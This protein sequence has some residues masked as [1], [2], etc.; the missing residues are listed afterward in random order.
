MGGAR[1]GQPPTR[2][3]M[4]AV[5]LVKESWYGYTSVRICMYEFQNVYKMPVTYCENRKNYNKGRDYALL[6][7][8]T[9]ALST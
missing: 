1:S 5:Y 2:L 4:K 8:I 6:Q 3:A 9:Q 7:S